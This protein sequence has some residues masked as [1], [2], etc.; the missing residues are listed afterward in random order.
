MPTRQIGKPKI[1]DPNTD[2]MFNSVPNCFK[3]APNLPVY[4]LPQYH[5]QTRRRDEVKVSDFGSVAVEKN[6]A[7]QFWRECR[8][9][10]SIQRHLIFLVYLVSRVGKSLRECA[11]VRQ[12][13]QTFRLRVEPADIEKAGKLL[14]K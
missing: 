13:K 1:S 3:H 7:Q 9:P 14:W 4:A 6:S 10:R 11:I 12:K 8:V 2:K 5:A